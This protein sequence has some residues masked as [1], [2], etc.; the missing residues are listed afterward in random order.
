MDTPEK[1]VLRRKKQ[2][3]SANFTLSDEYLNVFKRRGLITN[4]VATILKVSPFYFIEIKIQFNSIR[5][6]QFCVLIWY[7]N[8]KRIKE[9]LIGEFIFESLHWCKH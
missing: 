5:T 9:S 4:E 2:N 6:S 3:I 7:V 8:M 1:R